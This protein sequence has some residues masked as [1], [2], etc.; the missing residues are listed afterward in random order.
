MSRKS[1]LQ[2]I[3]RIV[4]VS[5]RSVSAALHGNGRVSPDLASRIREVARELS[6]QPNIMAR[7]L[8]QKRTY[9]L[10]VVFPF[11]SGSFYAEVLQGIEDRALKGGYRVVICSAG[12]N[13]RIEEQHLEDLALR[14]VDGIIIVPNQDEEATYSSLQSRRIAH[15]QVLQRNES[16]AGPCLRVLDEEGAWKMTSHLLRVHKVRPYHIPGDLSNKQARERLEGFRRAIVE[17]GLPFDREECVHP[18]SAI[19]WDHGREAMRW[20]LR[21]GRPIPRSIF[22]V[23]DYVALGLLRAAREAG[24]D[25][26]RELAVAGFDDLD[27]SRMQAGVSLSTVAQPKNIIGEM[28]VQMLL[29]QLAGKA[30]GSVDL[31]PDIVIR[32]SCG[33]LG[34]LS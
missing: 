10:G 17:A 15:V 5:P 33:G 19:S 18:G 12:W 24:L 8:V 9:L 11:V 34:N 26:P 2:D 16:L 1:T 31:S 25:V 21:S 7:G 32:E 22:A 14:G 3:A 4:G 30:V 20:L 27:M 13:S 23:N 6:Y 29:D 28:A